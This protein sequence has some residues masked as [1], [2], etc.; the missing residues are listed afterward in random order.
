MLLEIGDIVKMRKPHP[1]GS[2]EWTIT[3]VGA[4]IKMRCRGCDHLV[5]LD[6]P[7]FEKRLKAIIEHAK[8]TECVKKEG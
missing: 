3:R 7:T 8:E 6:R 2:S 4:D 5:M 1:C